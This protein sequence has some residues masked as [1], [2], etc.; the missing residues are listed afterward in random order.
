MAEFA[1]MLLFAH[2]RR[3]ALAGAQDL[4]ILFIGLELLVLPGYMLAGFAKRDGLSTEGAI[5][6]FLLGSFSSAILLFGLVLRVRLHRHDQHRRDRR[7]A[8]R[9]SRR[10]AGAAARRSRWAWR[11]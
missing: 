6:Y 11:C 8:E 9:R 4:L 10:R 7:R 3:D 1:A 5:K 2:Q